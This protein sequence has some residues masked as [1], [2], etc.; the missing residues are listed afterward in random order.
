MCTSR[1]ISPERCSTSTVETGLPLPS[2]L[3]GGRDGLFATLGNGANPGMVRISPDGDLYIAD[4]GLE[5]IHIVDGQTGLVTGQV[6][7]GGELAAPGFTIGFTFDDDD[8]LVGRS[9][10]LFQ[11]SIFRVDENGGVTDVVPT[12]PQLL[13]SVNS[14]LI[15]PGGQLFVADMFGNTVVRFDDTSGVNPAFTVIPPAIP[16]PLPTGAAFPSNFPA[17]LALDADGTLLVGV[18]GLT[19]PSMG[20]ENR[21]ALLRYDLDGNLLD[22][23]IEGISPVSS[24]LLLPEAS[25]GDYNGNGQ[26]EQGDLD[27]VLLNW[28]AN[29]ADLPETWT[30][31]RPAD[32]VVDQAELDRVL[33]NWGAGAAAPGGATSVPEPGALAM[34][35]LLLL[36]AWIGRRRA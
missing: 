16:D 7:S 28:G 23:L 18:L 5:T 9:S 15:A 20:G 34:L 13:A 19:N 2:P 24:I 22:T 36:A 30:N 4:A 33:L 29:A 21:G 31:E 8:V 6:T 14:M 11:G 35:S 26:T 12:D 32:G 17:D 3:D 10:P 1:A 25:L 27:L